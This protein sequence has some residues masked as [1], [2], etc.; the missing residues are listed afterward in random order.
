MS[1]YWRSVLTFSPSDLPTFLTAFKSAPIFIPFDATAS[2]GGQDISSL[3][4][5]AINK[6]LSFP[7]AIGCYPD[8]SSSQIQRI[9][10]VETQAF[11]LAALNSTPSMFDSTCSA[12]HPVYGVL[13]VLRTRLPFSDSR[14][15]IAKQ[16]AEVTSDAAS[17]VVL[18]VG[19]LLS[20]LPAPNVTDLT[21][22]DVD[23]RDFGTM[24]HL[25]HIALKWLQSF[26]NVSLAKEAAQFLLSSPT[27]P[28]SSNSLLFNATFLPTVEVAIF[29]NIFLSDFSSFISSFSTPSGSL[30]FG[31]AQAQEFRRW[32]LQQSS[33]T[34][35]WSQS[36]FATQTAPEGSLPNSSFEQI[37]SAA[38]ALTTGPTNSSTIQDV[39]NALGSAGL[40]S[41]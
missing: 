17:R 3:L 22:F 28:P 12:S 8:L 37:W 16:A 7:P 24:S 5:A 6:T 35:S 29:G 36:T 25:N 1:I 33:A 30:F 13:D 41:P 11:G 38:F 31:S 32:A 14:S 26:P 34:I 10:A 20:A 27:T 15:G 2:P 9:S 21:A 40:L 18:H 19:E 4:T 23:P 39:V